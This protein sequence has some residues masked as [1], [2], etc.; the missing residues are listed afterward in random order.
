M[1][2]NI[3]FLS[4]L[5]CLALFLSAC[6]ANDYPV[7]LQDSNQAG[8]FPALPLPQSDGGPFEVDININMNTIDNFLNRPD[9]AYFDLRMFYDPAN[10]REIGS[11]PMIT[12]TL[13]G[14]RQVP[15]PFIATLAAMPVSGSY[16]G[17]SLFRIVWGEN[18]QI[19]EVAPNFLES[20]IILSDL[21]P[22]DKA[23]FL[24]CNGGGYNS[25][26][27]SLLVHKGWDENMIYNIGG[28][29]YYTGDNSIDLIIQPE[30][31]PEPIIA[32]WRV[33]Y[34]LIDFSRLTRITR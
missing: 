23:I 17:D 1:G 27:K 6:T 9:V 24:M 19:L 34:A 26:L 33:N 22:K 31:S 25:M 28:N 8:F 16:T 13:P 29:W 10:F 14:F 7:N 11:N 3:F 12:R 4:V 32:T 30:G 18:R 2:K 5:F 15:F 21:F 20:E